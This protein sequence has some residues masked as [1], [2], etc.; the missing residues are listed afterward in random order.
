M[1]SYL[2]WIEG[3]PPKRNV[4]GSNPPE[5]RSGQGKIAQSSPVFI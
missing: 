3:S 4:G 2:S 5:D 1:S